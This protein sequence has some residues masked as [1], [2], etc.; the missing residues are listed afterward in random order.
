VKAPRLNRKL[1]LEG[2]LRS[3]DGAGGFSEV[4]VPLGTLWAEV[5]ARTGRERAEAGTPVSTVSYR[6][7]VRAAPVGAPSRPGPQQ[8]LR[9]GARVYVIQAVSEHDLEG[10]FL[11]CFADEEVA[12]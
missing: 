8:R 5:N 9:D 3:P 7:V 12:A 2:T 11:T 10:R 4:W 6:I 1:V